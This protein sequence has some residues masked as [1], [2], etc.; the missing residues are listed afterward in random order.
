MTAVMMGE[1]SETNFGPSGELDA[2]MEAGAQAYRSQNFRDVEKNYKE[3]VNLAETIHPHDQR[4]V[5]SLAFSRL[6]LSDLR[7]E[8]TSLGALAGCLRSLKRDSLLMNRVRR[9]MSTRH[10][11]HHQFLLTLAEL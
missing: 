6:S 4:V 7:L 9:L 11:K 10:W 3:A 1:R 5:T 2:A 8:F